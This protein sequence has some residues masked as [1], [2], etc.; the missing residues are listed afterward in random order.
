MLP[1]KVTLSIKLRI[2]LI[3]NPKTLKTEFK[4]VKQ[5]VKLVK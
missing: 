4:S 2:T 3:L 5:T 1:L